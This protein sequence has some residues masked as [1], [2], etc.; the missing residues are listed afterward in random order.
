MRILVAKGREGTF[1]GVKSVLPIHEPPEAPGGVRPP[2]DRMLREEAGE[3][4]EVTLFF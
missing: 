1:F 2:G 4:L 3:S